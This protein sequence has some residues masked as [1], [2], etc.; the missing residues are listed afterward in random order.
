MTYGVIYIY[1]PPFSFLDAKDLD[2]CCWV[3][4]RSAYADDAGPME[5]A[6]ECRVGP[7]QLKASHRPRPLSPPLYAVSPLLPK[8]GDG[9]G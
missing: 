8:A 2:G 1:P 5:I 7:D 6:A 9:N 3:L 4:S